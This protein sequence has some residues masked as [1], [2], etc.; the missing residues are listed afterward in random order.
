[1]KRIPLIHPIYLDVPMLVSFAAATQGGLALETEVTAEKKSSGSIDA[2]AI[3]NIG[4]NKLFQALVDAKASVEGK[5]N[6]SSESHELRKESKSYTEASIAIL[7]YHQ[8]HQ[9]G[10]YIL[11]PKSINDFQ[12]IE[13]GTLVEVAG[14][15]E[16][17]AVDTIIDYIDAIDILGRLASPQPQAQQKGKGTSRSKNSRSEIGQL[18][19]ALDEDRKRT[20]ISN[21]VVRCSEP[22]DLNVVATLRTENL[23]DLTL[24]E[25]DKNSVRIVGKIT[26]TI[27]EG[28][29]MSS[30]EN[31]GMALLK[32]NILNQVFSTISEDDN[33][34]AKFT[35]VQIAGPAFQLL[36][37]MIF[38]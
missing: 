4:T 3:G 17:N 22:E 8:L 20:P 5:G 24:S 19:D 30:F 26:R 9:N 21:V 36:P 34:V 37:L 14:I 7:L 13:S 38:V 12:E 33:I 2:N 25:L 32:P 28:E 16:K 27:G 6:H 10:E 35:D 31:Y 1:M 18:R 15:V 29:T 11:Q 23:R